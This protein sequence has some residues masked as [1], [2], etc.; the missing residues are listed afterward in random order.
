MTKIEKYLFPKTVRECLEMLAEYS[1]DARVVS[2]ATD[3]TLWIKEGKVAPKVLVDV[4]DIAELKIL[5]AVGGKMTLGAALTH[6][7]VAADEKVKKYFPSLSDGCRS[8]GSP[9]IRNLGTLAGNIVSAQPAADS[10]VPMTALNATCEIVGMD[11]TRTEALSKLTKT[12][13]VSYVD[14]TKEI[15]TKIIIGIPGG[16]YG[17]AFKRISPREAMSLPIVNTAVMLKVDENG[18]ISEARIVASPV[19]TV[20]FRANEAEKILL[21]KKPSAE[22]FSEAGRLAGAE[23]SPRDSLQRGSGAYRKM[24]VNDLVNQALTDAAKAFM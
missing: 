8:V 16:R 6:A 22:L 13:G 10:V 20:P 4:S 14:P 11:G 9:Q 2:G 17:T 23:A 19:A 18:R 24:L 21:G 5:E 15:I 1:G 3:L 12:V 7:E